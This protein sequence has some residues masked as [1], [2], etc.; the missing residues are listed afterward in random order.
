MSQ[1]RNGRRGRS[2]CAR[3]C[4]TGTGRC[5]PR[6]ESLLRYARSGCRRR[7]LGVQQAD[8]VSG[9]LHLRLG[10]PTPLVPAAL[11]DW[12]RSHAGVALSAQGVLKLPVGSAEPLLALEEA[13]ASLAGLSEQGL[14]ARPL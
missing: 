14:A 9:H 6:C 13:L 12:V 7:R 3:R 10:E 8:L 5:R 2:G 11:L 4:A 1:V